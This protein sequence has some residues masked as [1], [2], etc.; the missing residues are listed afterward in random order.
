MA[1]VIAAERPDS[2]DA[3]L[4]IGELEAVL[5]PLYAAESRHGYSVDKLL[6]E[7]VAFFVTR[8]DGQPAGCGGVLLVGQDYAEVKRMFVRA[9]YRGQGLG[10]LLLAH[11]ADY[12][13]QHG[14][15]RLRL[16]TGIHQLDAIRLYE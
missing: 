13:R 3:Q 9:Q 4:L 16:E 1:I 12:A 11:L 6:R 5:Q 15:R 7:G 10:Q 8:V 14:L 2:P